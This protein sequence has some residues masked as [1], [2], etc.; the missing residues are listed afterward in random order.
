MQDVNSEKKSKRASSKS[1]AYSQEG[2][3]HNN[4]LTNSFGELVWTGGLQVYSK[5]KKLC[6]LIRA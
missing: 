6:Y 5:V 3:Q 4:T 2:L 1:L